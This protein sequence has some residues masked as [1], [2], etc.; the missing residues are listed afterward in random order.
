MMAICDGRNMSPF[1]LWRFLKLFR[2]KGVTILTRAGTAQIIGPGVFV[3]SGKADKL[4]EAHSVLSALRAPES[5]A[6]QP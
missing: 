1:Y 6:L 2:E 5:D 4:V 3:F